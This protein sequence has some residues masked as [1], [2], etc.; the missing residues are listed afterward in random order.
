MA[1]YWISIPAVLLLL[2]ASIGCAP[3]ANLQLDMPSPE[4]LLP[5]P[6][7]KSPDCGDACEPCDEVSPQCVDE[8]SPGSKSAGVQLAG[9]STGLMQMAAGTMLSAVGTAGAAVGSVANF[10]VPV[11]VI[12]PP[13]VPPPGR[14][15]PVPTTPVFAPRS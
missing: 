10:F 2:A 8:A 9:Y 4:S 12:A 1:S 6:N 15:H 11:S 5:W 14:F 13:D 3:I 7:A